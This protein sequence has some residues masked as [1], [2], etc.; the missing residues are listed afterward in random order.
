L[1]NDK[2]HDDSLAPIRVRRHIAK[3][4]FRTLLAVIT[5]MTVGHADAL[6]E[7]SHTN[8]VFARDHLGFGVGFCN[9]AD[10]PV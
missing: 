9:S 1:Q 5:E 7:S 6:G 4:R 2:W 10:L 8:R 3:N